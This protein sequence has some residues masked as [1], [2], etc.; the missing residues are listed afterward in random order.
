MK[1]VLTFI[2]L[3]LGFVIFVS[4]QQAPMLSVS[5]PRSYTFTLDGGSQSFSF[6]C[7]RDWSVS[8]TESWISVSPSSG[9]ASDGET[10]V[11]IRCNPNTTYDPRIA[12]LTIKVEELAETITV[13]Q[14]TG[15][16]LIVSPK[17]FDLTNAEQVIEIEV[18]KN[19]QYSITIDDAGKSWITHTDT[20]GL[21]TEKAVFSIAANDTY[22]NREAK[23][24]FSQTDGNL[25]E[26]VVV[27]QS[28]TN[29]LFITT[30]E[31]DLS[32]EEHTLSVE[33]KANVLFQ[34]SPQVDWI[35]YVE[36]RA[37]TS[38]TIVL[39]IE[40][41]KTYDDRIGTVLVK[42]INGDLSGTI[43]II[44]KQT[45]GLFVTPTN[46]N[47]D[48][49]EQTIELEIKNNVS[50]DVIIPDNSKDWISVQSN[51]ATRALADNK[52]VLFIAQNTT[53][54]N[55][56]ASVTIKQT[57]GALTETVKIKQAQT[58]AIFITT[59]E[60]NLSQESHTLGV[61]VSANVEYDV[62]PEVDWIHYVK[63]R[64][65]NTSIITLSVDANE[66][67]F[68]RE[69]TVTLRQINGC[70]FGVITVNQA[71]APDG[72]IQF[73]DPIAKYA[74]VEKFDTNGDGEISFSEAAA[75]TSLKGL[76]TDWNTVTKFDE[77]K[78]FTG[79]TST[80]AVFNGL[81]KLESITIPDNI[82]TLG[83]FQNCSA[84]ETVVLPAALT[85]LPTYCFDGCSAL[86][87]VNLPTHITSIPEGCFRKCHSLTSINLPTNLSEIGLYAFN[88][89][90]SLIGL[91][92]PSNLISIGSYAFQDCSSIKSITLPSNL[93]NLG[94]S[95][96][97]QCS[98][99]VSLILPDSLLNIPDSC[100][101][102]CTSLSSIIWPN[103]L[104]SIGNYTFHNCR[105]ENAGFTV[106]LP[107]TVTSI[108]YSAF[109]N[110][111]HLILPS[112][113]PISIAADS[114]ICYYTL[115][116]V[117]ANMVEMY[118]VRTNWS[119]YADRIRPI[120][121]YPAELSVGGVI[122]EPVDLGLSVKWASWNIGAS[123]PDGHG[124][125]FAWGETS[126]K[127]EYV[128]TTYKWYNDYT[129][130]YTKYAND[131][132]TSLELV[133]DTASAIWG[134][135]WRMPT[136]SEI[137]ELINNCTIVQATVNGVNGL[138][139]YGNKEGYTDKSIFLPT[140]TYY[141][142]SVHVFRS[143][144]YG[145]LVNSPSVPWPYFTE[146]HLGQR[147]RPVCD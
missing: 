56:E 55:R 38:S 130:E 37:L 11:T 31:Y 46:F 103:T 132:K 6:T 121:D 73:D 91:V 87:E 5:G 102:N 29:G 28:Q 42:Q 145:L 109:G 9:S 24:T 49:L 15:I 66:S 13:N 122:G 131:D 139:F 64:T 26:T 60:Y 86:K 112:T 141:S 52:V 57:N 90:T 129:H 50:F 69:G 23:I 127:W 71:S 142:S 65:L 77:I 80:D 110:I 88:G 22:D 47:L 3:A 62:H 108:G 34:V 72:Y 45:D 106:E 25:S 113:S 126:I 59:P 115:L 89:C 96:F 100:F 48:N 133:D 7:N 17:T 68:V 81:S 40:A 79:V 92:F 104:S 98:S 76:F 146:R 41:N 128:L 19:V 85:T 74:C 70:L 61:E 84:L 134:S 116:Y 18:Q 4:C 143:N 27:R 75:V 51:T 125:V 20:K 114:F 44:Q 107:S 99:L 118:K 105:F 117:P 33:I 54:D 53:F 12:T 140:G 138:R 120:S 101:S 111:H 82:A 14:E 124:D 135:P 95:A 43:T 67:F 21:S 63:T 123:T 58:D 2:A 8:T 93:T 137:Y 39:L 32:N 1:R 94:K 97:D 36:T 35:K 78:Y 119:N 16:G 136:V 83:T 147:V 10:T 144:A 30:P